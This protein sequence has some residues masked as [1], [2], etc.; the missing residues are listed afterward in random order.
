MSATLQGGSV[1]LYPYVLPGNRIQVQM[2]EKFLDPLL[3][4]ET[5][6]S[7]VYPGPPIFANRNMPFE[8]PS[9]LPMEKN[10][11]AYTL[12]LPKDGNASPS[13]APSAPSTH[14]SSRKASNFVLGFKMLMWVT[15]AI[16]VAPL[17]RIK[18]LLQ[19]QNEMIKSGR[20]SSPYK[21]FT[22]CLTRTIRH[23]GV[24][25]LW[26][27]NNAYLLKIALSVPLIKYTDDFLRA[28]P[29]RRFD[30]K[31]WSLENLALHGFIYSTMA[32]IYY[33]LYYVQARLATDV[34][35]TSE[36]RLL[37][38]S[39][40]RFGSSNIANDANGRQFSGMLGV[41]KSTMKSDG[42]RGF[43]RGYTI[44]CVGSIL[45]FYLLSRI[46][47]TSREKHKKKKLWNALQ[48]YFL[49]ETVPLV[50]YPFDS[51]SRRMMMTSGNTSKYKGTI[52]AFRHIVKHEGFLSLYKGAGTF[53]VHSH[54]KAML[55]HVLT[56]S[57]ISGLQE[58]EK[59]L[60]KGSR[61]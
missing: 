44:S 30:F 19:C 45:G 20:L 50:F 58:F 53:I 14:A 34:K 46:R 27:G 51:V 6:R 3:F 21:G 29:P 5:L 17:D 8:R 52:D 7:Y 10:I 18:L 42:I 41:C 2:A 36:F 59:L 13:S 16:V 35:T 39:A 28:N 40:R 38:D 9:Y 4:R 49:A 23:E 15:G 32:V 24:L 11:L 12:V 54:A 31:Q 43:Y 1:V 25:S 33:P 37:F 22:D 47:N 56:K 61:R 55:V 57:A 48:L 60:G 26:R